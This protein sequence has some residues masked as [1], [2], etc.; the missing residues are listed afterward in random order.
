MLNEPAVTALKTWINKYR[1]EGGLIKVYFSRE[2]TAEE[3][4]VLH[5]KI[6]FVND[7]GIY[8]LNMVPD[9]LTR[10]CTKSYTCIYM[11]MATSTLHLLQSNEIQPASE[12]VFPLMSVVTQQSAGTPSCEM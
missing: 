8:M 9:D 2:L 12:G 4:D 10:L 5:T 6:N 11:E 7:D 3:L 1:G